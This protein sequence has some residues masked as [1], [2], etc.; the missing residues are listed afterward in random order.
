NL[1]WLLWKA[2]SLQANLFG[3]VGPNAA[4]FF[5]ELVLMLVIISLHEG[6]LFVAQGW[7]RAHNLL[8]SAAS[9]KIGNQ[10]LH[11]NPAGRKL[12]TTTTINEGNLSLHI[13]PP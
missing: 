11:G 3:H 7:H 10:V 12:Q 2:H 1:T 4:V 5:V 8:I 6:D 13:L 9:L